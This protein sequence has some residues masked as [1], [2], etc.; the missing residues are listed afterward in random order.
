MWR[1]GSPLELMSV[2]HAGMEQAIAA[3]VL[4]VVSPL[5]LEPLV[6]QEHRAIFAGT[7]DRLVPPDQVAD[8]WHHWGEP[9]IHWYQGAHLTFGLD[10]NVDGLIAETLAGAG[11]A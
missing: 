3:E 2:E 4:H 11:L 6:P 5:A 9:R 7:A 1:H 8:L 10:K